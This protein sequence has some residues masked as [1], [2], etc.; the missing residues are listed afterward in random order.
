[1]M[2]IS[3]INEYETE[4]SSLMTPEIAERL[5][6]LKPEDRDKVLDVV[7]KIIPNRDQRILKERGQDA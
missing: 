3:I 6:K 7:A 1:M 4:V 2:G 5:L